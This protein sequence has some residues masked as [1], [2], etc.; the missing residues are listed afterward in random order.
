M[1]RFFVISTALATCL[2]FGA[3][4]RHSFEDTKV[5]Y[6]P[7]GGSHDEHGHEGEDSHEGGDASHA[8][9]EHAGE[10]GGEKKAAEKH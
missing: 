3:C 9:A 8:D 1:N 7:H 2:Y 5:L 10:A 6:Q 4:E